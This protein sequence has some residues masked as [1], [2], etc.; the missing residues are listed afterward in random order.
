VTHGTHPRPELSESQTPGGA[1]FRLTSL[2]LREVRVPFRFSFKHALAERKEAH[3]LFVAIRSDSGHTGYG[4]VLP[5]PYLTGETV[6]SAW[7]DIRER[8]WPAVRALEF[9][10]D[11]PPAETLRDMYLE[12]DAA[13]K[14]GSYAGVDI[15]TH[16]AWGHATRTP[17]RVLFGQNSCAERLT[18]ALGGGGLRAVRWS[19][20]L[21][22]LAGFREF[23]LKTGRADDLERIRAARAVLGP[24]CDL[25]IDANAGWTV[26]QT[27]DMAPTLRECG[28]SSIEQPIPAGDVEDLARIQREAG[29]DV[30][31]DESLC[32]RADAEA[33]LAAGA[34]N[35]WNVRLA[36][37]GGFTG[38][39]ELLGLARQAGVRINLGVLVG[40]SA[41]LTAAARACAGLADFAHVEFGFPRILLKYQPFRG[42]PGG[43]RGTGKPLRSHA[44]L[45][46]G[47]NPAVLDRF[48]VR[49]L[50][51]T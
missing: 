10:I 1:S 36:K 37:V 22:K 29:L 19:G 43:Y 11:R 45:G 13:R 5:R 32:S 2:E 35:L 31:A 51:L 3:N 7:Q 15:A 16:Y 47:P 8:W 49:K 17:G 50:D 30:V 34:A 44:G 4:E 14:T 40:E 48:S 18:C 42:D 21:G 25:R 39:L 9:R 46:V 38:V 28:V 26:E 27:L 12:A 6:S 41:V 23:K 24:D 20:R 33:L